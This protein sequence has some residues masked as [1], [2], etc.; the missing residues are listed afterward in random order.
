MFVLK[1]ISFR[2]ENE[3]GIGNWGLG[4]WLW[5][6]NGWGNVLVVGW[7]SKIL[8]YESIS[9][10]KLLFIDF[11]IIYLVLKKVYFYSIKYISVGNPCNAQEPTF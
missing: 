8:K 6:L 7:I 1:M 3:M 2:R 4:I 10:I 9:H 11:I 5:E